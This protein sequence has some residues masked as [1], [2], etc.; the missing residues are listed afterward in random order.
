M[1]SLPGSFSPR[2]LLAQHGLRYSRA[3]S[4]ILA[5]L[6]ERGQH[7]SAETLHSELHRRGERVS[8]S[9]VY[10][11]LKLLS[12]LG[13]LRRFG[14]ARAQALYDSQPGAHHHL[15]C[16]GCGKTL[17]LPPFNYRGVPLAELLKACAEKE[18]GWRVD[19][20]TLDL[21]GYCPACRFGGGK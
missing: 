13:V 8:L 20:T 15:I 14:R 6:K 2:D 4:V 7:V 1:T 3:R 19:A 11:N 9:T 5:V 21:Y 12:E 10:A 16:L 18:T 17:D